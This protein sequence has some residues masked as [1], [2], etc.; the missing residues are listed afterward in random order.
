MALEND[1]TEKLLA[2]VEKLEPGVDL[3]VYSLPEA[4]GV[5]CIKATWSALQQRKSSVVA[6]TQAALREVTDEM[7]A[8]NLVE[9]AN[10]NLAHE[11]AAARQVASQILAAGGPDLSFMSDEALVS[12]LR[13]WADGVVVATHRP[14]LDIESASA[15]M[16]VVIERLGART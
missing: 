7:L 15:A 13:E 6:I 1:R 9:A 4:P 12:G 3:E 11:V 14:R 5:V 2:E 16:K 10:A 8:T